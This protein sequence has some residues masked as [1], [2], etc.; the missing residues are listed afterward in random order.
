MA[1][2]YL[3]N[4]VRFLNNMDEGNISPS[5]AT[6]MK[7]SKATAFINNHPQYKYYK[8]NSGTSSKRN[9]YVICTKIKL[10]GN[11]TSIV[12]DFSKAKSF[13]SVEEAYSYINKYRNK[14]SSEILY[15]VDEKFKRYKNP[16]NKPKTINIDEEFEKNFHPNNRKEDIY[17]QNIHTSKR[18]E[19]PQRVKEAVYKRTG[20]ICP[21]CKKP[22]HG[23]YNIDH[24]KP[25]K[26]GGTN[27]FS[28]LMATHKECNDFKGGFSK[29]ELNKRSANI[30]LIQ[31]MEDPRSEFANQVIRAIVRGTIAQMQIT[32]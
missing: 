3:C 29:N 6:R 23:E 7:L 28:N 15:V 31:L 19:I 11:N 32:I 22:M 16:N 8:I 10:L 2:Y 25:L 12:D 13:D 5:S 1:K 26:D 4:D 20:D 21:I 30:S 18:I 14:I 9:N 24:N 27:V 17:F